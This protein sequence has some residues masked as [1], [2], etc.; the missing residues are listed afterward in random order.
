MNKRRHPLYMCLDIP[1]LFHLYDRNSMYS[2]FWYRSLVCLIKILNITITKILRLLNLFSIFANCPRQEQK[3][4]NEASNFQHRSHCG[5]E[6]DDLYAENK[7][8]A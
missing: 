1:H 4:N 5:I 3:E 7:T 6:E 2:M 8:N